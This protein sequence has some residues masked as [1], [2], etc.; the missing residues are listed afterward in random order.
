MDYSQQNKQALNLFKDRY[1]QHCSID[2]TDN[3]DQYCP[4]DARILNRDGK[5]LAIIESKS[6][7]FPSTKYN[8]LLT[9][10]KK[11]TT[12]LSKAAEIGCSAYLL[13]YFID[14]SKIYWIELIDGNGNVNINFRLTYELQRKNNQDHE[15]INKLVTRIPISICESFDTPEF[16]YQEAEEYYL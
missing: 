15:K 8:H 10:F 5:I 11:I 6:R 16:I 7:P 2:I 4:Y 9:D 13:H 12:V 14:D 1:F 3:Y